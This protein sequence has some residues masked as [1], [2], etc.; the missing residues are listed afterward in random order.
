M[1]PSNKKSSG[2]VFTEGNTGSLDEQPQTERSAE[3]RHEDN[4]SV[5]VIVKR[6]DET[7]RHPDDILEKAIEEGLE[8]IFRPFLSLL[9]SSVAAGLILSFTVMAVGVIASLVTTMTHNPHLLRLST[10]FVYPLG[11]IL[12]IMSGTQLFTEHTATAVYPVLDGKAGFSRLLRLWTIVLS[13]NLVGSVISAVLLTSSDAMI[14]AEKGYIIIA[15]H[16]VGHNPIQLI[17]SATSAGWLMALGGWLVVAAPPAISQMLSI[18]IV[19]F[20]IGLGGLHHSI[21]G[22]IEILTGF[23]ISDEFTFYQVVRFIGLAVLGNIIG[24]SVFVAVLNYAHIRKTQ[25]V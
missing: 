2:I 6:I 25:E 16:L 13:G 19:T 14:Q 7:V 5:P 4:I 24:G 22:S 10:A 8:Q 11:F 17:L 18:F 20:L 12:C 15:H 9:F 21:A 3:R 1:K 23:L